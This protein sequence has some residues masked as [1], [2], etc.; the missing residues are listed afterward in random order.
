MA[1][2]TKQQKTPNTK[3]HALP[4]GIAVDVML[5]GTVLGTITMA[6]NQFLSEAGNVSYSGGIAARAGWQLPGT[7]P[8]DTIGRLSFA[9]RTVDAGQDGETVQLE[10][11]KTGVKT[12]GRGRVKDTDKFRDEAITVS[13]L[14]NLELPVRGSDDTLDYV[15]SVRPEY[16]KGKGAWT[17]NT[18]AVVKPQPGNTGGVAI[19]G[20]VEGLVCLNV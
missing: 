17:L 3:G 7:D 13:H 19:R 16:L 18:Q 6:Q 5:D 4:V 8:T 15:V 20:Q 11:A 2:S 9:A 14:A 10:M 12:A 1:N